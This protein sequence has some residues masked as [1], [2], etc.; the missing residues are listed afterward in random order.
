MR[1]VFSGIPHSSAAVRIFSFLFATAFA[2]ASVVYLL[3]RAVM[4][5]GWVF[6]ALYRMF[7][8][9]WQHPFQ[10]IALVTLVYALLA[11]A[12][13][14]RWPL[15]AGKRR[16]AAIFAILLGTILVSS[17]PGGA[18]WKIHDMQAGYF[19]AANRFWSDLLWGAKQGLLL[20]W[21]IIT[22]SVPYNVI[23]LAAGYF[24]TKR[25]FDL[26]RQESGKP[27]H[28]EPERVD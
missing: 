27:E 24:L 23:G 20:G 17:A 12:V 25:G 16:A 7:L 4:P 3:L 8:Y 21:L 6:G 14:M 5:H 19:P 2:C 18:L 28:G 15:L 13:I 22:L 1:I 11:T 10:Y 9:H 26:A